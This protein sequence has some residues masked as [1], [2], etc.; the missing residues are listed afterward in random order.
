MKNKI[1]CQT[2]QDKSFCNFG[3]NGFH[4]NFPNGVH[5]SV[6]WSSGSYSDNYDKIG[7]FYSFLNSNTC[8]VMFNGVPKR[9]E[10]EILKHFKSISQ[11]LAYLTME[12]FMWLL[13][14]LWRYKPKSRVKINKKE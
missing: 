7:E 2:C 10:K 14:K 9:I 13:K 6:I 8:E 4:F 5:L 3:H 11:P 12:D 1:K